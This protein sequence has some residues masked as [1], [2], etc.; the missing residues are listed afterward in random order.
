MRNNSL[1]T[2]K[3]LI[4]D[5]C[6]ILVSLFQ[7]CGSKIVDLTL[8]AFFVSCHSYFLYCSLQVRKRSK[9]K[10]SNCRKRNKEKEQIRLRVTILQKAIYVTEKNCESNI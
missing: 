5:I 4:F 7:R 2:V 8:F 9:W 1:Y 3:L 10:S 6:L